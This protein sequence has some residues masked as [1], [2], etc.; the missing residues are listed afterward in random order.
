MS[1]KELRQEL[2]KLKISFYDIEFIQCKG[3]STNKGN[4]RADEIAN[5]AMDTLDK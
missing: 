1:A 5:N 2:F 4:N 3:H